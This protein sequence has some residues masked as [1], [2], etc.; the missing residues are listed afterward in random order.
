MLLWNLNTGA[1]EQLQP[2]DEAGKPLAFEPRL[3]EGRGARL[4]LRVPNALYVVDL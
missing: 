3:C 2:V 1:V 4:Y